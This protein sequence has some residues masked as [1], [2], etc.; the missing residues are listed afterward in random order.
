MT[1]TVIIIGAVG[2]VLVRL[3]RVLPGLV[4]SLR[5]PKDSPH[6]TQPSTPSLLQRRRHRD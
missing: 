5:C 1:E 3:V 4:W 2:A 6:Y